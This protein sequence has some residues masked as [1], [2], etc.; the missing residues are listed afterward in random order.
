[1]RNEGVLS[2]FKGMSGPLCTIPLVNAVVFWSYAMAK[3]FLHRLQSEKKPLQLWEITLAGS[4]AGLVNCLIICPVELV[5]TRLQVQFEPHLLPHPIKALHRAK[6]F[7]ASAVT[8][9]A[10]A[11]SLPSSARPAGL[12][13]VQ[14]LLAPISSLPHSPA[15][16][17]PIDCVQR[18]VQQNGVKGLFRGMSATIYREVPAYGGQFFCYEALKRFLTPPGEKGN[19]LSAARLLLAGGTAGTFGWILSYPMDFVKSQLQ[20]EPYNQPTPW[21][22]HTV[23]LDGGFIDC[24]QRTVKELGW[25]ALWRGFGPCLARAFPANAAGFFTYELTLKLLRAVD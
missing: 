2:L 10:A 25:R 3:N 22:K 8:S 13:R 16:H 18:I 21:K 15:F 1:M 12:A 23:L 20:S 5:K 4:F 17:G 7:A 6:P 9:T 19:D 24:W 11:S 14:P